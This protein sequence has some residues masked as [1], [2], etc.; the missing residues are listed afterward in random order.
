MF[1]LQSLV[2]AALNSFTAAGVLPL[3][4]DTQLLDNDGPAALA[5]SASDVENL[6]NEL[7][8]KVLLA[9]ESCFGNLKHFVSIR[10][11]LRYGLASVPAPS[12]TQ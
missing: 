5:E 1:C 7:T 6:Q 9:L 3:E 4:N 12:L 2:Q 11:T 10:K 8:C